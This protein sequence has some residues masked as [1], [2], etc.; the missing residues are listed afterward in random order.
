M[1]DSLWVALGLVLVIE[2]LGPLFAPRGWKQMLGEIS[3]LPESQLRR[4]GGCL[5]IAG[6]VIVYCMS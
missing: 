2:G 5:F 4:I 1:S 6:L 3:Q